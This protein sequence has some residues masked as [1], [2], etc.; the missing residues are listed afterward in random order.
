MRSPLKGSYARKRS[1]YEAEATISA[2]RTARVEPPVPKL[3][4]RYLPH[5]PARVTMSYVSPHWNLT[6]KSPIGS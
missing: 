4:G 3:F 5:H 6:V 1:A 2:S